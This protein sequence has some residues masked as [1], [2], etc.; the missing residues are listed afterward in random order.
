MTNE[1]FPVPGCGSGRCLLCPRMCGADRRKCA[2]FCGAGPDPEVSK[3]MLHHWEEPPVSGPDPTDEAHGS[4][5]VFF[6]H[7]SLGCVYCQNRKISRRTSMGTVLSPVALADELLKL[8]KS[9]AYNVNLVSPTH[10]ADRLAETVRIARDRGLT[11]PVVWNT[12]G[13][14]RPETVR[15]LVEAGTADVWLTDFKYASPDLARRCSGAED[16]PKAAAAALAVMAETAGPCVFD[17]NGMIRRGVIVRHL[18]LPGCRKDSVQVL[19]QIASIADVKAV[20]LSLMAQ[21]TPDFLPPAPDAVQGDAADPY[22]S[23]R[24][25]VTTYEYEKVA[26]EAVRLGFEGWMQERSSATKRFT[27]DF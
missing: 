11:L 18:I 27:P 4:G 12:G 16:Y 7:C 6:T 8:E 13:Y 24:R 9:G 22:R 17:E 15:A 21:Y 10:W 1:S 14:E 2:G 26:E 25:K 19:R 5:A 20:R 23:I 3:I